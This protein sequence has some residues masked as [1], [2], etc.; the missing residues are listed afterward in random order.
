M[1]PVEI[2]AARRK[3]GLTQDELAEVLGLSAGTVI[4]RA[5]RGTSSLGKPAQILLH[6]YTHGIR[7]ENWP[8]PLWVFDEGEGED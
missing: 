1:T 6:L 8:R 5:E 3:L 2:R 4:S 7:P